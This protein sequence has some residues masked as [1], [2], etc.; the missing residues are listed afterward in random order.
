MMDG[1]V[2]ILVTNKQLL[3]SGHTTYKTILCKAISAIM[4]PI[5]CGLWWGSECNWPGG[6]MWGWY[7]V[8]LEDCIGD[9][10]AGFNKA[11]S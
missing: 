6:C 5:E 2:C 7:R 4:L 8:S 3:S 9:V 11:S 1:V 10:S